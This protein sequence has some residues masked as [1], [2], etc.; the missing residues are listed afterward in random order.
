MRKTTLKTAEVPGKA[1]A[2]PEAYLAGPFGKPLLSGIDGYPKPHF[3]ERMAQAV[4][5]VDAPDSRPL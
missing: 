3:L 4:A 2:C 5:R 1:K